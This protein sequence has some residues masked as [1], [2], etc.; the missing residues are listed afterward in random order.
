MSDCMCD[1]PCPNLEQYGNCDGD[2][3]DPMTGAVPPAQ[4]PTFEERRQKIKDYVL[5]NYT[6]EIKHRPA[7]TGWRAKPWSYHIADENGTHIGY[8][9]YFKTEAKARAGAYKD[10]HKIIAKAQS[11][12]QATEKV[13][14]KDLNMVEESKARYAAY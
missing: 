1:G 9:G 2:P 6:I 13:S 14:A 8:F 7:E 4:E 5:D 3:D 10:L 11:A 12:I